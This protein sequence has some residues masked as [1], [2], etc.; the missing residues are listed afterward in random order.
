[1]INE[2]LD[3][4]SLNLHDHHNQELVEINFTGTVLIDNL[5]DFVQLVL[6]GS[7]AQHFEDL[8]QLAG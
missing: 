5:D 3:D 8:E 1:M 4:P 2:K 7:E 6:G